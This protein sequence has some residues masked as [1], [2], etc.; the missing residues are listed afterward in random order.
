MHASLIMS[1]SDVVSDYTQNQA[2]AVFSVPMAQY[3]VHQYKQHASISMVPDEVW[4]LSPHSIEHQLYDTY[5]NDSMC[6]NAVLTGIMWLTPSG[7]R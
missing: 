3:H 4:E 5:H 1:A 7:R 6:I 2:T